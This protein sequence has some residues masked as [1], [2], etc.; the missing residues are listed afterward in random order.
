MSRS[1]VIK[2]LEEARAVLVPEEREQA[3]G[4][5]QI[6]LRELMY[7][8]ERF[9]GASR[10]DWEN[11]YTPKLYVDLLSAL[12]NAHLC[13]F[14][15]GDNAQIPASEWRPYTKH[16]KGPAYESGFWNGAFFIHEGDP[17]LEDRMPYIRQQDAVNWVKA[18]KPTPS[19]GRPQKKGKALAA[20]VQL[21]PNGHGSTPW[22]EIEREVSRVAG[23]R[24]STRTIQ[25]ALRDGELREK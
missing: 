16:S 19:R 6:L 9:N 5:E 25:A 3:P 2:F 11:G 18:S 1:S 14:T 8:C 4:P 20:Y 7:A 21:Y 22:K 23:E 15:T 17:R 10:L 12:K 13:A 24:I